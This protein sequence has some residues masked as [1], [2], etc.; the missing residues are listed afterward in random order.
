MLNQGVSWLQQAPSSRHMGPDRSGTLAL[1]LPGQAGERTGQ[2]PSGVAPAP[3]QGQ[4]WSP[5]PPCGSAGNRL[6][7]SC[8]PWD[9]LASGLAWPGFTFTHPPPRPGKKG[10]ERKKTGLTKT[11]PP[12]PPTLFWSPPSPCCLFISTLSA[13]LAF[14]FSFSFFSPLLRQSCSITQSGLELIAIPLPWS[15]TS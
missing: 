9:L 12:F 11:Y 15:L 10:K 8:M 14:L 1:A 7:V 2:Q 3:C 6:P 5:V 4:L 13:L